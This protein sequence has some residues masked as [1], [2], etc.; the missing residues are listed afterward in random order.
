MEGNFIDRKK[1]FIVNYGTYIIIITAVI[2]FSLLYFIKFDEVS[3]LEHVINYY[4][5]KKVKP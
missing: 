2:T 5:N 4:L 1:F 3:I